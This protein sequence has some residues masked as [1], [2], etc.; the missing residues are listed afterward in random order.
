MTGGLGSANDVGEAWRGGVTYLSSRITAPSLEPFPT[1]PPH[2][3]WLWHK[4]RGLSRTR[5]SAATRVYPAKCTILGTSSRAPRSLLAETAET[6]MLGKIIFRSAAS[7]E[8]SP[9][10]YSI[11][12][13]RIGRAQVTV[14]GL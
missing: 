7:Y 13:G 1:L 5:S 11:V 2:L 12:K 4:T 10:G 6:F 3:T 14:L 8:K 9:T